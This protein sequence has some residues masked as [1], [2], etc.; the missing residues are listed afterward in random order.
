MMDPAAAMTAVTIGLLG[1]VH[2][3]GMCGGIAAALSLAVPEAERSS[4]ALWARQLSYGAGR[5]TSYAIAGAFVGSL[6][7]VLVDFTGPQ[8]AFAL[9][10]VA[11]VLLA[12]IGLQLGGWWSGA[13]VI[14]RFGARVWSWISPA[15]DTRGRR[16]SLPYAFGIGVGWG[17][18]PCGLVYST[19]AWSAA[20]A[21]PID[22]SLRMLFFGLGTLP[23]VLL[24]GVAAARFSALLRR[25]DARKLAGATVVALAVWTLFSARG[26]LAAGDGSCA[27]GHHPAPPQSAAP[28]ED[29]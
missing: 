10:A 28:V 3:V 15:L 16:G 26:L 22:A 8:G 11:A 4:P 27:H 5:V 18:L 2:C 7:L 14:E 9:R 19:L 21:D 24:T 29:R 20:S 25:S 12:M 6:G 1:G 23:A 13:A 17:W